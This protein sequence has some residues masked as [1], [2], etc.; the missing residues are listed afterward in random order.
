MY[1]DHGR[2]PAEA[3]SNSPPSPEKHGRPQK[4]RGGSTLRELLG[5]SSSPGSK[6]DSAVESDISWAERFLG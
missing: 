2:L 1:D 3:F 5:G 6:V 4:K